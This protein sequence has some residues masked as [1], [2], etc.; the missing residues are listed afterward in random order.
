MNGEVGGAMMA[1][2]FMIIRAATEMV[3]ETEIQLPTTISG[4]EAL[5]EQLLHT[6]QLEVRLRAHIAMEALLQ[7][8][9]FITIVFIFLMMI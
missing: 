5:P 1:L 7:G 9:M 4:G 8:L 2:S 6:Q 3:T